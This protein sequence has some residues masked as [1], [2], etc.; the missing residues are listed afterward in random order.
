MDFNAKLM[1]ILIFGGIFTIYSL[2]LNG[3][4]K[5]IF[6]KIIFKK[7]VYT[8]FNTI[9]NYIYNEYLNLENNDKVYDIKSRV[10]SNIIMSANKKSNTFD[11]VVIFIF[12]TFISVSIAFANISLQ[13][14]ND[15]GNLDKLIDA[16]K[17][18]ITN[19]F[20][21]VLLSIGIIYTIKTF[22]NNVNKVRTEYYLLVQNTINEIEE[23]GK[24]NYKEKYK[25]QYLATKKRKM[26]EEDKKKEID[27]LN[28][29]IKKVEFGKD[30]LHII[31]LGILLIT[32][33]A[34][35]CILEKLKPYLG[36]E[37][38]F[39]AICAI[40]VTSLL[41]V[42]YKM[43]KLNQRKIE[44]Y[45]NKLK[46]VCIVNEEASIQKKVLIDLLIEDGASYTDNSSDIE[47]IMIKSNSYSEYN[48]VKKLS[49]YLNSYEPNMKLEETDNEEIVFKSSVEYYSDLYNTE[50]G[51]DEFLEYKLSKNENNRIRLKNINLITEIGLIISFGLACLAI[52]VSLILGMIDIRVTSIELSSKI[53][54]P[55]QEE[56]VENLDEIIKYFDTLS[57]FA[58]C[59]KGITYV[60]IVGVV[61][62]C[63]LRAYHFK[64]DNKKMI[65]L[66]IQKRAIE[67]VRKQ[68]IKKEVD[69]GGIK[70]A[71]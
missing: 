28:K 17:D 48:I 9:Y 42:F 30:S 52:F 47:S 65:A 55:T 27:Y 32:T 69:I 68:N 26:S 7:S 71:M 24:E 62:I 6:S 11:T 22:I 60:G 5:E 15:S 14:K 2:L 45:K 33:L 3:V 8:D 34:I 53:S 58:D 51:T 70:E 12:T 18:G 16:V 57:F 25:K 20:M 36:N 46:E 61:L 1:M 10:N 66:N 4:I 38:V 23:S 63:S 50:V 31:L 49:V 29:K 59:S 40:V 41:S 54:E 39:F 35:M 43:M 44:D 67:Y 64:V 56:Q 21:T 13:Y 19:N 37:I